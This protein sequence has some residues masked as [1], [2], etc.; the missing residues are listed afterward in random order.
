MKKLREVEN[1]L[2]HDDKEFAKYEHS[3]EKK[4]P[5]CSNCQNIVQKVLHKQSLWLAQYK[6]LLFKQKPIKR[7]IKVNF[8]L[9]Y[10]VN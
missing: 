1:S 3:F 10:L 6:M 8:S 9:Y 2:F 5:L 4:Y 7:I